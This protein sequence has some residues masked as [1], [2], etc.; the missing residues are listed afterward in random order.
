MFYC[1]RKP[2]TTLGVKMFH[3]YWKQEFRVIHHYFFLNWLLPGKT[4]MPMTAP[5]YIWQ[6][7]LAAA[8]GT[9]A[10]VLS[11][12]STH[13]VDIWK[14]RTNLTSNQINFLLAERLTKEGYRWISWNSRIH[15]EV[16]HNHANP[17]LKYFCSLSALQHKSV[18]LPK[19]LHSWGSPCAC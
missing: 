2:D 17:L 18:Q 6:Q 4:E 15:R 5:S 10:V 7:W 19:L 8:S 16:D 11:N 9:L 1:S 13:W 3:K 12:A 14:A